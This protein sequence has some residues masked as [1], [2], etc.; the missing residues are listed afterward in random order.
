MRAPRTAI[1]ARVRIGVVAGAALGVACVWSTA[2]AKDEDYPSRASVSAVSDA[3]QIIIRCSPI[4]PPGATPRIRCRFTQM[5][6]KPP[7]SPADIEKEIAGFEALCKRDAATIA[8]GCAD[9]PKELPPDGPERVL[10]TALDAACR[11]HSVPQ[12]VQAFADYQRQYE[13]HTCKLEQVG[14]WQDDFEKVDANTW[15][16]N[17][18][19]EGLCHVSHV[20]TLWRDS[21]S[22]S[23]LWHYRVVETAPTVS[24]PK[25]LC[26]GIGTQV[27]EYSWRNIRTRDLGCRYIEM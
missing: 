27:A 12:Y 23:Y 17:S 6:I 2:F 13:A 18:G 8:K 19:P 9:Q 11:A 15:I 21:A 24:D 14:D 4:Q 1:L 5:I 22:S 20:L 7:P 26:T 10:H 25:S 16:S 3:S